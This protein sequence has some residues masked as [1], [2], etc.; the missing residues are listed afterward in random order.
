M[1]DFIEIRRIEHETIDLLARRRP[2]ERWQLYALGEAA[3]KVASAALQKIAGL[4]ILLPSTALMYSAVIGGVQMVAGALFKSHDTRIFY[5]R[6]DV[7]LSICSGMLASVANVLGPVAF[8]YGAD[9]A[10]RTF[11]VTM[12]IVPS[13]FL[14]QMLFA[15]HLNIRQYVSVLVFL[16]GAWGILDGP[17]IW[18]LITDPP[19]WV[20]ITLI[21]MMTGSI[22]EALKNGMSRDYSTMANNFWVGLTAAI[23]SIGLFALLLGFWPWYA[24][25]ADVDGM[26]ILVS[27]LTG[28]IVVVMISMGLRSYQSGAYI[29]LKKVLMTS[30]YL[31][32][33]AIVGWLF[34]NESLTVLRWI[35][36]A[37]F[38]V[39]VF[40]SDTKAV[41][42]V[43]KRS[44]P[45]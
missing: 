30:M 33:A 39:A 7:I 26:F 22:N 5:S 4:T 19:T 8:M 6:K 18:T 16:V 45:M 38:V 44:A 43:F 23:V 11:I 15:Q 24:E 31:V 32:G 2:M 34:F 25:V 20:L 14:G 36:I 9:L 13:M 1:V 27:I 3:S 29:V 28:M 10:G 40:L 17:N 21:V 35:G 41:Q 12:A 42:F 37:L